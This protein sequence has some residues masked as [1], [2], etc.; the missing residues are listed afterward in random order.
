MST[1]NV[2]KRSAGKD[3]ESLIPR[4]CFCGERFI[5]EHKDGVAAA[6]VS[7]EDLETLE[8]VDGVLPEK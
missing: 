5:I 4:A 1:Y 7:M 8:Q 6:L 2:T 3:L